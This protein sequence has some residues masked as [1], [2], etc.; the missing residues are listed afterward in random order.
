VSS[1]SADT[2]AQWALGIV[3][4]MIAG[5][6]DGY[7]LLYLGVYVSFMTGNTTMTGLSSGQ[8]NLHAALPPA[9]A[10]AFFFAGSFFGSLF[11]QLRWRY[12]HRI[13]FGLI[14]ILVAVAAG[15]ER[16]GVRNALFEIATLSLAMGMMNPA[17]SRIGAESVS[18]TFMTGTLKRIAGRLAFAVGRKFLPDSQGQ[19][20][21]NLRRAGVEASLWSA[22]LVGA[23]ISGA[24]LSHLRTWALL[25]PVAAMIC[26]AVCGRF[27]RAD[28]HHSSERAIR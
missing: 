10:I 4:V 15:F 18:L 8:G 21:S 6:L 27:D 23:A 14:A 28:P 20:D 3:L 26:L 17:L 25:P 12:S 1:L 11:M 16:H 7:G 5:Y 22:F 13:I 19:P 2:R 9:V 24:V